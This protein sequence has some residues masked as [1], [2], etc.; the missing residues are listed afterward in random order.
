MLGQHRWQQDN[1]ESWTPVDQSKPRK[2]LCPL[3]PDVGA[4]VT[5]EKLDAT[6]NIWKEQDRL[7]SLKIIGKRYSFLFEDVWFI[8]IQYLYFEKFVVHNAMYLSSKAGELT[9]DNGFFGEEYDPEYILKNFGFMSFNLTFTALIG[10]GGLVTIPFCFKMIKQRKAKTKIFYIL[11]LIQIL[12]QTIFPIMRAV[13]VILQVSDL[14]SS[15]ESGFFYIWP[16]NHCI[17][18][19]FQVHSFRI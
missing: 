4:L 3:G 9:G 17:L 7:T 14:A 6:V 5:A 1:D 16:I 15:Q 8:L 12:L 19:G 18:V 13:I 10:L 2:S 11:T